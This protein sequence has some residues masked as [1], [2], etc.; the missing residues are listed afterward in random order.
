M[1]IILTPTFTP[2]VATVS[3]AAMVPD[4]SA[5]LPGC[6]SLVI[7]RSAR[8]IVTDLC[9]R[10]KVWREEVLPIALVASQSQYGM[11]AP[12]GFSEP[13]DILQGY[14]LYP[15]GTKVELPYT[16][17]SYARR[18]FPDWPE[19]SEGQPV[20]V[21]R[22][23]FGAVSLA[24]TPNAVGELHV[25]VALRPT[26]DATEW[27]QTLYDV[28]HRVIFHGVLHELMQMHGRSWEDEK[29]ALYHGKQWTYLLNLARDRA[30]RG[31]NVDDLS[32]E[33]RP[34]A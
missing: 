34:F 17:Y 3:F 24:P 12:Y 30:E 14:I 5:Y 4:I 9:Q 32:V 25:V 15:D 23:I 8:K 10:A 26:S 7:E 1:T 13:T 11:D 31:Y 6:P 20:L 16:A 2:S 29:K 22:N 28:H 27:L 18:R 19:S 21:T 33:M